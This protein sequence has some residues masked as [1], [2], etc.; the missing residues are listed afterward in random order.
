MKIKTHGNTI[1]YN[2]DCFYVN[3]TPKL[4]ISEY[5]CPSYKRISIPANF[6][7]Y[8]VDSWLFTPIT[9]QIVLGLFIRLRSLTNSNCLYFIIKKYLYHMMFLPKVRQGE[10]FTSVCC[11]LWW[12]MILKIL[13]HST[14]IIMLMCSC[15][16][17]NLN[18]P[19]LW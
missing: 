15:I 5:I 9:V 16:Q 10:C 14:F 7:T 18:K 1:I 12:N 6:S 2:V 19:Q 8:I 3:T 13:K 11:Y 17:W 4:K